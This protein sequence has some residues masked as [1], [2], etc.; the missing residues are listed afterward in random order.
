MKK[1]SLLFAA[2][3]G[4]ICILPVKTHAEFNEQVLCKRRSVGVTKYKKLSVP[5][6]YD[7]VET[8]ML[9]SDFRKPANDIPW[10]DTKIL[11]DP[12]VGERIGVLDRNYIPNASRIHTA[13]MRNLIVAVGIDYHPNLGV[14]RR[15]EFDVMMIP[16]GDS[17]F[18]LRGCD[19]R[20]P[21]TKEVSE[22]LRS[23]PP[24][25]NIF[26]KLYAEGFGGGVL[27]QIGSKTVE[28][29]KKIYA[30]W[31]QSEVVRPNELGF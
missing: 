2:A 1:F 9:D 18:V 14:T 8:Y 11:E 19:G 22:A 30:N 13:W 15:Y 20:F 6:G 24:G 3:T 21:V 28:Q 23:Q 12:V 7:N 17:Y 5:D 16:L 10:S 4:L 25:K 26:V 29:W 31:D 27:N